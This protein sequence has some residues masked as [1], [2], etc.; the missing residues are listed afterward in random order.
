MMFVIAV[1]VLLAVVLLAALYAYWVT[2]FVPKRTEDIYLLPSGEQYDGHREHM[3]RCIDRLNAVPYEA[4]T[5]RAF[6]G[7]QLFGRY[8]HVREG[9]PVQLQ[10]HGYRGGALRDLCGGTPFAIRLGHN[11]LLVD[12]RAHG[13]SE[14]RTITFGARE[15]RDCQSWCRYAYERFGKST[16]LILSGVSMGAATVLMASDMELPETVKAVV[17][18]CPY[19]SAGEIIGQVAGTLGLPGKPS[20]VFCSIGALVYGRF[21]LGSA[22]ALESVKRTKLPVLLIHGEDDRFVPCDMSRRLYAACGSEVRLETFPKA[23]HGMSYMQDPKRYEEVVQS[24]L[25]KH[26]AS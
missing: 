22:S 21:R 25:E 13:S 18:D 23:A 7:K 15:R 1:G 17:A 20:A 11:V 4:V 9:A 2:F 8:Y 5:I 3:R 16:P 19:T 6:D 26:L 12:Q 14:G 10:F 24:F